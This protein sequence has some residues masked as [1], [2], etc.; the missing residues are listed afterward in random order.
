[1]S[2]VSARLPKPNYTPPVYSRKAAAYLTNLKQKTNETRKSRDSAYLPALKDSFLD[3][4]SDTTG[5]GSNGISNRKQDINITYD[6][7]PPAL[8]K[9]KVHLPIV[10]KKVHRSISNNRLAPKVINP[11]GIGKSRQLSY[12]P[13]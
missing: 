9:P 5:S 6:Y 4:S 1:M 3:K 13:R 11:Y 2:Q 8:K 12:L 10:G 7:V